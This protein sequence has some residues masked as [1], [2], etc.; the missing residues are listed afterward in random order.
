MAF[1]P[2][3]LPD[4]HLETTGWFYRARMEP[5]D[6]LREDRSPESKYTKLQNYN[7]Q[8]KTAFSLGI[9]LGKKLEEIEDDGRRWN[10]LA[11]LWTEMILYIAPSD[12]AKDHIQHLANGGEFLTH[13]WT[14][15][16]HAGILERDQQNTDQ[17][18][19]E[20]INT[21]NSVDHQEVS[22]SV[23]NHEAATLPVH[24]ELVPIHNSGSA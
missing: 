21:H 22:E 16:T 17:P 8:E 12:N 4:H 11:D 6:L 20:N 14:L 7:E 15:L 10:I 3:L 19:E 24:L 1:V 2:E 18:R 5:L 23:A 9:R 13:M